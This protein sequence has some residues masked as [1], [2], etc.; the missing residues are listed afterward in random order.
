MA[1]LSFN[2]PKLRTIDMSKDSKNKAYSQISFV[3]KSDK[4]AT[5]KDS[6]LDY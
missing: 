5:S 4:L 3:K 1:D 6:S 2:Y